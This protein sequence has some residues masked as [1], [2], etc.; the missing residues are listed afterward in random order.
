M[1][2]HQIGMDLVHDLLTFRLLSLS[3]DV[4]CIEQFSSRCLRVNLDTEA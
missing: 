2:Q 3:G 1:I 4:S